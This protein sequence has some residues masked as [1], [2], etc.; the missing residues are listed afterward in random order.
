MI[1]QLTKEQA[2]KEHRN[3]WN[4]IADQYK[5]GCIESIY[6]VESKYI[7]ECTNYSPYEI[8]N[9]SFC[10]EYCKQNDVADL[11]D[12]CPLVWDKKT[13]YCACIQT[14]KLN[15]DGDFTGLY[16]EVADETWDSSEI[17]FDKVYKLCKQI[18][19]LPERK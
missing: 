17:D 2:I 11:C 9:N 5:S 7:K 10:C 19:N 6:D 3:M 15:E 18:A 8:E 13:S 16:Q 14:D 4:W 1:M 12:S